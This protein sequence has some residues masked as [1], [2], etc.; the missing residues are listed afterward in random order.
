VRIT[1]PFDREVFL[2][3]AN[4]WLST[5][6]RYF[7][8]RVASVQYFAGT[9]SLGVVTNGPGF[10]FQWTKVPA[11][12]YALTATATDISGTNIVTSAS[13]HITV[14]PKGWAVEHADTEPAAANGGQ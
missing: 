7:P 14:K 3:P 4:V 13:V 11:G 12:F 8:D 2:A 1:T 9:N 5:M 10:W 6:T